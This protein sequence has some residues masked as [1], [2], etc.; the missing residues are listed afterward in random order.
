MIEVYNFD[1]RVQIALAHRM[2]DDHAERAAW[3]DWMERHGFDLTDPPVPGVIVRD[4]LLHQIAYRRVKRDGNGN[5]L[6]DDREG[7]EDLVLRFDLGPLP[8][9]EVAP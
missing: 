4:A 6:W 3:M 2:P 8:F 1:E 9:P 5:P 7:C